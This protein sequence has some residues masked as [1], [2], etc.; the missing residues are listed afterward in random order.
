MRPKEACVFLVATILFACSSQD[1][2]T[3][4]YLNAIRPFLD[5]FTDAANAYT[6]EMDRQITL[7]YS[8]MSRQQAV[9]LL[10]QSVRL[11]DRA[12]V[13]SKEAIAG[14]KTVLPP[15]KCKAALV[16]IMESLQFSEQ[17]FTELKSYFSLSMVGV[18]ADKRRLEGN[19][20]LAQ[21]DLVKIK[22]TSEI[23]ECK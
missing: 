6:T 8:T 7:N 5:P 23:V 18:N 9:S 13:T 20:L 14:L 4:Q 22:N 10:D 1:N 3:A 12:L 15:G 19:R 16:A 11:I 2:S 21:A 17:G